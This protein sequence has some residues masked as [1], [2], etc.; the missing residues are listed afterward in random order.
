[1]FKIK[2]ENGWR[3][4]LIYDDRYN[5]IPSMFS[6]K[7]KED[8]LLT[9]ETFS[10]HDRTYTVIRGL[11]AQGIF[12]IDISVE[13]SL[14][15]RFMT[16]GNLGC[17]RKTKSDT[18]YEYL[19]SIYSISDSNR[20]LYYN[21]I[22]DV[23]N[24]PKKQLYIYVIPKTPSENNSCPFNIGYRDDDDI[25]IATKQFT[26]GVTIYFSETNN[27]DKWIIHELQSTPQ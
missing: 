17:D 20:T 7:N 2:P 19:S 15:F 6:L 21:R 3:D 22:W 27:I 9:T 12:K 25:Y 1:M 13:D 26:K 5:I 14:P 11:V 16:Y 18:I 4:F 24:T 8:D 10:K 23:N